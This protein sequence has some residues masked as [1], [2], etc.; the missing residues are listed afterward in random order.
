MPRSAPTPCRHPGCAQVLTTPGYCES[1][2]SLAHKDYSN[3]RRSFDRELGFY[4]STRWRAMRAA[5]L[6]DSPLC[7]KCQAKGLFRAAKVVDH[8][9]AIKQGGARFERLNLQSLCVPCHNAKTASETAAGRRAGPLQ[10]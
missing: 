10:G 1:H 3:A 2:Q 6:A 8:I 4:Q 9:L 5:V 7:C